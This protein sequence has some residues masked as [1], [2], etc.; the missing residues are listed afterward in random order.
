MLGIEEKAVAS[1]VSGIFPG[2][3][4]FDFRGAIRRDS[5]ERVHIIVEG[6]GAWARAW[7]RMAALVCHFPNYER[8]ESLRTRITWIGLTRDDVDDF[9]YEHREL[10][11]NCFWRTVVPEE[12]TVKVRTH[13]PVYEGRRKDFVDVEFEFVIARFTNSIV[14]QKLERWTADPGR[15]LTVIFC[16]PD[17]DTNI[18]RGRRTLAGAGPASPG[19]QVLCYAPGRE[20]ERGIRIFGDTSEAEARYDEMM[21]MAKYLNYFY[22]ASY[23]MRHVPVELPREEVEK[24]WA[25]VTNPRI[26]LS[27]LF[28][29][30][31]MASKMRTLGHR[32]DDWRNFYAL[33]AS[34]I[35]EMTPTE[36]NRWSLERLLQ[37]SRPCTDTERR[38]IEAD[39]SLKRKY[40]QERD[41]H[42][43]LVA[44]DE[45][46][47]DETGRNVACY[48]S[49]LIAAIPLIAK[50]F[51]DAAHEQA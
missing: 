16:G 49:D 27:N 4:E 45:L 29:V 41:A 51:N 43:D 10:F 37:G 17:A 38:E 22:A 2:G 24:A 35:E 5:E 21:D 26:R 13:R 14:Q 33:T 3:P 46:G 19:I 40:K 42:Y 9:V 28:N 25:S 23:E 50:S 7:V 34:E 31:T 12:D 11:D 18:F 6:S 1:M 32:R 39:I 48:D 8:K 15:Q 20:G 36:H 47:V 30:M 44:F